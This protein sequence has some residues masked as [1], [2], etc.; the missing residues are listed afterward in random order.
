M[1]TAV[2]AERVLADICNR[3][4]TATTLVEL[5]QHV[6]VVLVLKRG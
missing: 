6:N 1:N 4:G 5:V 2:T 3:V